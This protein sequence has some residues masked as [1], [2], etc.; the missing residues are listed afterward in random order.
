MPRTIRRFAPII[1]LAA[2]LFAQNGDVAGET[3]A[4]PPA[5]W[6]IPPSPVL[7]PQEEAR[8]FKVAP[9]FRIELIAA[10]PLVRDPIV[11]QFGPD[12]RIWV[13][14]MPGYMR[15]VEGTGANDPIG[16]I[17]VLSDTD[18][19]G[20]MD[21]RTVFL[22]GLVLARALCLVDGG[23]LF[24]EP[25]KLWFARDTDGDGVADSKVEVADDYGGTGNV[26]H[27]PNGLMWAL[28]N[29]IYNA[30]HNVRF[31]YAGGG[32]FTRESTIARGQWGIT[33]D[34]TGRLYYNSNSDPLRVDLMPSGYYKRNGNL[35]L[36]T[37][38]NFQPAPATLPV[39]PGRITP[40]VNRGYKTLRPDGTLPAVTAACSP[41]IY[42]GTLFPPEFRGDAF[43]CEASVNL[44]KR[45]VLTDRDGRM[46][47]ANAYPKTEFLTSTDERFRP[48]SLTNGP[49]GGL[50]LVDLYRGIIQD[51]VY[52]TSYLRQQ[53]EA[54]G[55]AKPTGLGRIWRIVPDTAPPADLKLPLAQ[56]SPAELARALG[57]ANG[58]TRD[59]AQRLLVEKRGTLAAAAAVTAV[60]EFAAKTEN[61]LG[62]LHA[63][64]TL[65]GLDAIDRAAVLGG[66]GD[67]DARV[68]AAVIRLAEKFLRPEVDAEIFGRLRTLAGRPEAAVRLQL[69]LSLGE[70]RTPEADAVL[71]SLLAS[72]GTQPFMI[73]AI[74]SGLAGREEQFAEALA[75][76]AKAG[77][78]ASTGAISATATAVMKSSAA[79][80][81]A[82]LLALTTDANAPAWARTAVLDGVE[83][84]L[85]RMSDGKVLAANLTAEPTPLLA[86]AAQ[87]TA[88]SARAKKLVASLRWPGKPGMAALEP[89]KLSAEE[90][91]RFDRGK[92]QFVSLCAACHQPEGQ[93]M[94]GLAP[95]L[96]NS[97]WALG[98]ERIAARIVLVGKANGNLTMPALRD[99]LNDEAIAAALT[100]VR[101]SW[102]HTAGP[103]SPD[104]IAAARA[105]VAK[106]TEPFSEADLEA[107]T[108][109]LGPPR[110]PRKARK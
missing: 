57:H 23:V 31:R 91:A 7:S 46:Q 28:D 32:K 66:L 73:E 27:L 101:N 93:G 43:I 86:L 84:F 20:R 34:D 22:D 19:D 30:N 61:P 14:E 89:V 94:P 51:R 104:V 2:P 103:V 97:R 8:T 9:G 50:W 109:E 78:A 80:R 24:A 4:P 64:W 58:W 83:R 16:R 6:V 63:W 59:T 39:W 3:Q 18:G 81:I 1:L 88:E 53:I 96:V 60:R 56:A 48:V 95:P 47:G 21:R 54:R 72:A 75:H 65:D 49:D 26:E 35:A 69:A 29:W 105:A 13:V 15:D 110:R 42:R 41:V 106:Q 100:Y 55:L 74:V 90:Q 62:R 10:E 70:A 45:I 108:L 99:A 11:M 25:P 5:H 87:N 85:P 38:T 44:V 33:Q 12:G 37:G 102:G 77:G 67:R 92:L 98:D 76:E 71:R 17:V 40:G 79:P 68:C 82:R 107:L 52:I 36:R